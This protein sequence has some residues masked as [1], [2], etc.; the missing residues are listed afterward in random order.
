M[1]RATFVQLKPGADP[2]AL[3]KNM[4]PFMAQHNA[5][6]PDLIIRAFVFDNLKNPN[7]GAYDVIRRPTEALHPLGYVVFGG[8]AL[9]MLALSCFNYINISLSQAARRLKEIG[10]RKAVGG[11]KQQLVWQF[12]SE[13]LL[14]CAIALAIGLALTTSL[15][16][17]FFNN[18]FVEKISLDFSAGIGIYVFLAALLLLLA[19]A[20]GAYPAL[21]I[22]SFQA[23]SIFR[24]KSAFSTKSRLA[25]VFLCLQFI[26]A[27]GTVITGV[28]VNNLADYWKNL[29]WGYRPDQTLVVRLETPE[30]FQKLRNEALRHPRIL[31]TG[32]AAS[33]I[34]ESMESI[35][36]TVGNRE[37]KMVRYQVGAGYFESL[38]LELLQGRFFDARRRV[39]DERSVV[40]NET[41]LSENYLDTAPGSR[42]YSEGKTYDVVGVV[43]DFKMVGTAANRP[44]AF[45]LAPDSALAYLTLRYEAGAG[46]QVE[47]FMKNAWDQLRT[48]VPFLFF[49]QNLVFDNE[50]RA[51][52]NLSKAFTWLSG[53]ALLIACM[54]LFGLASQNYAARM[55][56]SGIRKVLGASAGH[57]ILRAN[58]GFIL[59]LGVASLLATGLCFGGFQLFISMA[60]EFTGRVSLGVLPYLL[61]NSLVFLVAAAAVGWQSWRLA[62][63][64]PSETLRSE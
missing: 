29:P 46:G 39:E 57:I 64:A 47:S 30:Q 9:L 59:L 42:L 11:R 21:Y 58:R 28:L 19:L 35:T 36:G 49:H 34:G 37:S 54:G 41:F 61:A 32:C 31:H 53:L 14:L 12:M 10:V 43:K 38:G 44:A 27:F 20:S 48:G 3:A 50:Y 51:F 23:V 24:G 7:P 63:V 45:F 60:E 5:A 25:K 26:L 18:T 33:H 13:N 8:I 62:G 1:T 6:N 2:A 4:T 22:S 55:R 52:D 16:I 15:F 40:V 17:P 56:E